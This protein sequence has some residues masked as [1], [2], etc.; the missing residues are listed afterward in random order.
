M[1]LNGLTLHGFVL[2]SVLRYRRRKRQITDILN[3]LFGH[4]GRYWPDRVII[5]MLLLLHRLTATTESL[6]RTKLASLSFHLISFKYIYKSKNIIL[7]N[8]LK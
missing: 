6:S 8:T 3:I 1:F 2:A 7:S 5:L 4:E